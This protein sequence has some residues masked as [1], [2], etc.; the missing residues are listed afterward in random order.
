MLKQRAV[1][2]VVIVALTL[3][4]AIL[5]RLTFTLFTTVILGLAAR[6]LFALFRHAGHRPLTVAGYATV[7]ALPAIALTRQ[8]GAWSA[9]LIAAVVLLPLLPLLARRD[10]AGALTD[11]ALTVT[12]ALYI[13]LPAAH[14]VLLREL[15]GNLGSVADW[16]DASG[17]WQLRG[18]DATARGLS[19]FLLAQ[20]VTWLTDVGAYLVGRRWGRRKLAPRISPGKSV[21]GAIGGLA[22]GA[23]SAWGCAALFGLGLRPLVALGAGLLLSLA[24]QLGDLAESLLKRQAGVKDSGALVPGHG[25]ILDRLDSLLVVVVVTY[26]LALLTG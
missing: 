21:E 19:W 14:F 18:Y 3:G 2:S 5:G 1:S 20:V 8:W 10:H 9:P 16:L 25:G 12:G 23:L 24:G 4:A 15:P 6:E 26:Y 17:R 22:A 7:A 11:W 13:G